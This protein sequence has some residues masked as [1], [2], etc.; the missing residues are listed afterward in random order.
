M[1]Y[2][3]M[4]TKDE[5]KDYSGENIAGKLAG[6]IKEQ[7][8]LFD[9]LCKRAYRIVKTQL[10]GIKVTDLDDDDIANW[11]ILIMEQAEYLLS[12]GDKS[13]IDDDVN[14]SSQI[15]ILAREFALWSPNIRRVW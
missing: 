2:I 10:P 1:Q 5:F 12:V 11:K 14:L 4:P 8:K 13:L 3:V 6:D 15:E 7:D 9:I